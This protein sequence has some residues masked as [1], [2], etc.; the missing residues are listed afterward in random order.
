[1]LLDFYKNLAS[2][3]SLVWNT[4][5][6]VMCGQPGIRC[7]FLSQVEG[8]ELANFALQG[9]INTVLTNLTAL[10]RLVLSSNALTGTIPSELS[11]MVRLNILKLDKNWL[12]GTIPFT[13]DILPLNELLLAGNSYSCP[14]LDYSTW[15]PV[16][17]FPLA[18]CVPEAE[19]CPAVV[20][21]GTSWPAAL[22]GQTVEG[23]CPSGTVG[24]VV[25]TCVS[26]GLW[27]TP[28]VCTPCKPFAAEGQ[29]E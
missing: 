20:I 23:K 7:N 14:L 29:E 25:M 28:F 15:A 5:T 22:V 2:K 1:M 27:S 3:G 26:G 6:D 16:N 10:N 4:N 11:S 8:L 19:S 13:L 24:I 18:T 21:D 12:T 9:T 17:D